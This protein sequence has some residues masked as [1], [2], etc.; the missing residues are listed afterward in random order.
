MSVRVRAEVGEVAL[1]RSPLTL[2]PSLLLA[3]QDLIGALSDVEVASVGRLLHHSL[4]S[5]L[6]PAS[7]DLLTAVVDGDKGALFRAVTDG[8]LLCRAINV[9][10]PDTVDLRALNAPSEDREDGTQ[11]S[12]SLRSVC[13]AASH[14]S[15][16]AG[17]LIAEQLADNRRLCLNAAQ[18]AG[19]V[20]PSEFT[21][22]NFAIPSAALLNIV[23]EVAHAVVFAPVSLRKRPE[24]A[25]LIDEVRP[26][27]SLY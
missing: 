12:A 24:L 1:P 7:A 22:D 27:L 15:P 26:S 25:A 11:A 23:W 19:C 10:A 16:S 4:S 21:P 13:L 8:T 17:G 2:A 14:P 18:A 5:H 9:A 3:S 6:P 20:I